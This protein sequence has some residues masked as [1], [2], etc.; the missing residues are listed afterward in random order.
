MSHD[1]GAAQYAARVAATSLARKERGTLGIS[2]LTRA[3]V[4]RG[5]RSVQLRTRAGSEAP[6]QSPGAREG[7]GKVCVVKTPVGRAASKKKTPVAR[8]FDTS[9]DT[10]AW[11]PRASVLARALGRA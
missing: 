4:R 9:A 7:F 8:G 3:P 2:T 1:L 11:C 6:F 5:A 10:G